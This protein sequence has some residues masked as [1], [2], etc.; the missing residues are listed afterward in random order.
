MDFSNSPL[1][2]KGLNVLSQFLRKYDKPLLHLNI[3]NTSGTPKGYVP[4]L[5]ALQDNQ[6]I[7]QSIQT[8]SLSCNKLA[9]D[10]SN[11]LA[12]FILKSA[13]NLTELMIS[14]TQTNLKAI[15]EAV[16][17][18]KVQLKKLD[19]SRD[20]FAKQEDVDSLIDYLQ[21]NNSLEWLDLSHTSISVDLLEKVL[22][23]INPNLSLSLVLSDNSLGTNGGKMIGKIGYKLNNIYAIDLSDNDL[24]DD[25]IIDL[26]HGLQNNNSIQRLNISR[27]LK[28]GKNKQRAIEEI[29][30]LTS[31][32]CAVEAL[33]LTGKSHPLK[34][35]I[36]PLISALGANT[37][38]TE[39]DISGHQMGNTGAIALAKSLQLNTTISRLLW[40]E[41]L[42][43]LIGFKNIKSALKINNSLRYMPIPIYDIGDVLQQQS[44][45]T[46]QK[47]LQSTLAKIERSIL[48]N[49]LNS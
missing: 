36:I 31:S 41:N 20:K 4:V 2:D 48:N 34:H 22:V 5:N 43:G 26:C 1:E 16:S 15:L 30:K 9:L 29:I 45:E 14:A 17:Q 18:S 12:Q 25:G 3:S 40:D 10:G 37:T 27:N 23:S 49:Q 35:D 7:S 39:L 6:P 8:F 11:A 32:E 21:K 44:N 13:Y 19:I 24:G 42:T 47:K 38:I 46:E 28:G 33:I